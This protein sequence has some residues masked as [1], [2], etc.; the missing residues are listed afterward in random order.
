MWT[1]LKQFWT[2]PAQFR[3]GVRAM[4]GLGGAALLAGVVP[5]VDSDTAHKLGAFII[6]GAGIIPAGQQNVTPSS[7]R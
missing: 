4:I 3:A 1:I 7:V 5:H 6:G 2:D